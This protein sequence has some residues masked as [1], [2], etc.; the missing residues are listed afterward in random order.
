MIFI[1]GNLCTLFTIQKALCIT[2]IHF[3]SFPINL[4]K[5]LPFQ[6]SGILGKSAKLLYVVHIMKEGNQ[7]MNGCFIESYFFISECVSWNFISDQIK[8]YFTNV[9]NKD[10]DSMTY[11][12]ILG[13][14]LS[15]QKKR[16]YLFF[17]IEE[18]MSFTFI[19]KD[20]EIT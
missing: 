13:R 14:H 10:P 11:M 8:L 20:K 6:I 7:K 17:F 4:F 2:K 15:D 12:V 9:E 18:K 5:L 1:F 16:F 3:L 19:F